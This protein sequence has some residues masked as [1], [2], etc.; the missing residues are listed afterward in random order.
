MDGMLIGL[1]FFLLTVL[2]AGL[3]LLLFFGFDSIGE[4]FCER[5]G[6]SLGD[7]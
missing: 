4:V 1:L 5:L 7:S 3:L 6:V 2:A